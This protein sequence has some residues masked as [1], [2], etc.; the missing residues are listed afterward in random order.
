MIKGIHQSNK[1]AYSKYV[2]H[3]TDK[4]SNFYIDANFLMVSKE[5]FTKNTLTIEN[6]SSIIV[7]EAV[8][9]FGN[10]YGFSPSLFTNL[11][12]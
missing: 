6:L 12:W 4:T 11:R 7:D 1:N 2:F 3:I 9:Q 8:H 5:E 10:S